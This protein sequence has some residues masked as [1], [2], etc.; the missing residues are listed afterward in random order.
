MHFLGGDEFA[1][2]RADGTL[3]A[4]A[5]MPTISSS[6]LPSASNMATASSWPGSVSMMIFLDWGI[7]FPFG[8]SFWAGFKHDP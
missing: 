5:V 3:P 6:E 7:S 8:E 2:Q 4:T 1:R